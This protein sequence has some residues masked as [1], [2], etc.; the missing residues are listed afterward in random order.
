MLKAD[1]YGHGADLVADTLCNFSIG[2]DCRAAVDAVAVATIDEAAALPILAATVLVLRPVEN[3][4]IGRQREKIDEAVE[5]DWVLTLAS[6]PAADDLARVAMAR[7]KRAAVQV[8]V[9][10]GMTR[11]GVS[12]DRLDDLL[13]KIQSKNSLRLA[14]ICTHLANGEKPQDAYSVEQISRFRRATDAITSAMP[15]R[16]LRHVANSGGVF[17]APDSHLDMVRPG[18][19]FYGIDPSGRPDINRALKPVL[20]WTAPLISVQPVQKGT[21]V[22]YGQSW[23]SPR[24]TRIGLIPV[25][26]ADG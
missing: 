24:D 21:P 11:D 22:G 4:F 18:I 15:G 1:A 9:D 5:N 19:A 3:L 8:M 12:L 6:V 17:F 7:G 23:I 26:Y 10:T 14:G 20:R 25:G 2:T 13:H 16:F